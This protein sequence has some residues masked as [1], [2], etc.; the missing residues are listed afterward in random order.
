MVIQ[1]NLS[2]ENARRQ[3]NIVAK[4]KAQHAEKLSS[5]YR[6]NRAA[7][8]AA[9]LSL[10]EKM[11][12][13]I[14]GLNRGIENTQDGVSL[15]Q[16]ADGALNE[17]HDMIHRLETLSVQAAN[18]TNTRSDRELIQLEVGQLLTEI[19]RISDTTTFNEQNLFGGASAGEDT[20][21]QT[22][23]TGTESR[24]AQPHDGSV[25]AVKDSS[26][27]MIRKAA[28]AGRAAGTVC[29][30]FTVAGGV[31]GTDYT[32]SNGVLTILSAAALTIQNTDPAAATSNRIEVAKDVNANITL[33][34]VN[35][36]AV[37]SGEAAFKIADDSAGNVT[38]TLAGSNT[39]KSGDNHAGLEKN[40]TAGQLTIE[41]D[42]SLHAVGGIFGAGIGGGTFGAG[43]NITIKGGEVTATGGN[44]GAGIGGGDDGAGSNITISGG[45]VTATGGGYGAGIGGGAT[46]AGSN[47]TIKGGEV[48]A[49]GGDRGAGIGGGGY[50]AGSNIT[51]SGGKV[52]ATGGGDGAGI[53]GGAAEGS[54]GITIAGGIVM[55]TGGS[56]A[57]HIGSGGF[58]GSSSSADANRNGGLIVEGSTA[59]IYGSVTLDHDFTIDSGV[60]LDIDGNTAQN[61]SLTVAAGVTLTN[62]GTVNINKNDSLIVNG[63]FI[64]NG[65]VNNEGELAVNAGSGQVTGGGTITGNPPASV[66]NPPPSAGQDG[67]GS[68]R[69]AGGKSWWI[70]C[71]CE[72]GDGIFVE[73]DT[74]N[75]RVLGLNGL[76]VTTEQGADDAMGRISSALSY[77]STLR[78]KIGAQQNRLEH[79][80][81]NERNIVENTTDAESRIRDADFAKEAVAL[82]LAGILAQA[83]GSV[84]AQAN[85][86]SQGALALLQ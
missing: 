42:G 32:F 56:N 68:G 72:P 6:I 73:I 43:S 52:T 71:G 82:S 77:V 34:G 23:K 38:V 22:A 47:I 20:A 14:R 76:N 50:G 46:K 63:T 45:K 60:T 59:K 17:V 79:T 35:I 39:L 83:G 67:N 75:T 9:G 40:G 44:W 61:S 51:I 37:N 7:D 69:P 85:R 2:A 10:S 49:T 48:T 18:G 5:G 8:D 62:N 70:H 15:C 12:R 31:Q 1:H 81:A 57:D 33:A 28:A 78:S 36:D 54:S 55:A 30:D 4:T 53:G 11:R 65:I 24:L 19:D 3:Y 58:T 13:Q 86:S 84:L 27:P 25:Y 66:T 26:M 80:I 41:G 16:V 21:A 64:N 29:G 74:M